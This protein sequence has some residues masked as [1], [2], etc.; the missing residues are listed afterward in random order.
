MEENE[1][2][3]ESLS[4]SEF[5]EGKLNSNDRRDENSYEISKHQEDVKEEADSTLKDLMCMNDNGMFISEPEDCNSKEL[6]VEN[7][8][9]EYD[10]DP[11]K[12]YLTNVN[13]EGGG[14]FLP[15]CRISLVEEELKEHEASL[16]EHIELGTAS[17]CH[18]P[19]Q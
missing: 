6:V 19:K 3:H 15:S 14:L 5:A 7:M 8:A 18:K 4:R 10:Q 1:S 11:K 13:S 2:N 17:N 9:I 12:A 16:T